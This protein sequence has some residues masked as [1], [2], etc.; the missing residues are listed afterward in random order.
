[1]KS[2]FIFIYF[3]L[4]V[5]QNNFAQIYTTKKIDEIQLEADQFIGAD[6]FDHIYYINKN[7]L[8]RKNNEKVVEYKELQLGEIYSVDILNPLL[9]TV[10]YKEA[11]T[12]VILDNRLNELKRIAF[13]RIDEYKLVD[14]CTTANDQSLWIFNADLQQLEIFNY[15]TNTSQ[16]QAL[17]VT[18]EILNQ[19]SNFNFCWLQTK[20]GFEQYN[21]YGSLV[22]KEVIKYDIIEVDKNDILLIEKDLNALYFNHKNKQKSSLILPKIDFSQVHINNEKLYLYD[23][24]LIHVYQ[25]ITN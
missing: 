14:F 9:I 4:G 1:M 21:I 11:N 18:K 16:I 7:T 8:H 12:A 25:I 3:F 15:N 6:K 5:Y 20:D 24:K 22:N 10:F 2:L 23:E 13:D 19:K 17:P